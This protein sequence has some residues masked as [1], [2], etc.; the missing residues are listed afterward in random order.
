MAWLDVTSVILDPLF[1]TTVQI[2]RRAETIDGNGRS[3]IVPTTFADYGVVTPVSPSSLQRR[4]DAQLIDRAISFITKTRLWSAAQGYQPDQILF[5]GVLYTVN[6]VQ[7]LTQFGLG[8][9]EVL[10]L[11]MRAQDPSIV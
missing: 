4:D 10:A 5:N 6:D 9:V 11:S 7:P 1:A 3:V 2:T 8:F